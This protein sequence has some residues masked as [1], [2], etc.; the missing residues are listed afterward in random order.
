MTRL[1]ELTGKLLDGILSDT[2]WEELE[3][4]LRADAGAESSHNFILELE[5]AL[6]GLRTEFDLVEPTLARLQ[7]VQTEKTAQA[8]MAEIAGHDS[9]DWANRANRAREEL[10]QL[11]IVGG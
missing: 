1:D 3:E 10:G 2:E 7:D 5:G 8:V 11:A 4:L 9:P 6:R